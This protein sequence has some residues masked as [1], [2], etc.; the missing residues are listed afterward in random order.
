MQQLY[1][2]IGSYLDHRIDTPP[3]E[4]SAEKMHLSMDD[5]DVLET[6]ESKGPLYLQAAPGSTVSIHR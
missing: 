6:S 1:N 4:A 5:R 3:L 2:E